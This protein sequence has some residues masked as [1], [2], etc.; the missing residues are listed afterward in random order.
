[1]DSILKGDNGMEED[2]RMESMM[3]FNRLKTA[4]KAKGHFEVSGDSIVFMDGDKSFSTESCLGI[5]LRFRQPKGAQY[6]WAF[7]ANDKITMELG[8]WLKNKLNE[9]WAERFDQELHTNDL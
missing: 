2:N 8:E 6:R 9:V 4:Q 3:E 1:M 7:S 5:V